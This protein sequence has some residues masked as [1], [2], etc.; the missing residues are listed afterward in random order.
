MASLRKKP[1]VDAAANPETPV[2]AE[3]PPASEVVTSPPSDNTAAESLK[4]QLEAMRQS[5]A[6]QEL[7]AAKIAA[8]QH[9]RSWFEA[10]P[11]A[12]DNI[13]ALDSLHHAALNAGMADCSPAYFS[14]L[15]EQLAALQKPAQGATHL[16]HEIEQRIEHHRPP[17]PP[18]ERPRTP[19][20]S[21]PVSREAPSSDGRRVERG[22]VTLSRDEQEMAHRSGISIEEYAK[23]K[24]KLAQ[25]RAD[26]T[27]G[28]DQRR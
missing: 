9:R 6:M 22:R 7:Q 27:Y 18:P 17:E 28:G 5:E 16:A 13:A 25:M 1:T 20:M 12:K 3:T 11:G 15:N 21:A 24:M 23:Q 14:F 10:T 4:R 19:I 8:E 26:G 2:V